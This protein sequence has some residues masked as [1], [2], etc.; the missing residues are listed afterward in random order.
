MFPILVVVVRLRLG[1]RRIAAQA[2]YA[3]RWYLDGWN[4]RDWNVILRHPGVFV[5]TCGGAI[6]HLLKRMMYIR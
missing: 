4:I 2:T 6:S 1:V 3:V 5:F